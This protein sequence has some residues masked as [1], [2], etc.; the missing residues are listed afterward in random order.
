MPDQGRR[1]WREKAKRDIRQIG[2]A[3]LLGT[4]LFLLLGLYVARADKR[5][6]DVLRRHL[7]RAGHLDA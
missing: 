3:R 4:L 5:F 2:P 1:G 7:G 6:F